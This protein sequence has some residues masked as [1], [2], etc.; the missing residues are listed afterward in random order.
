VRWSHAAT[1]IAAAADRALKLFVTLPNDS[2]L[3]LQWSIDGL[4]GHSPAGAWDLEKSNASVVIG[5]LD[6]GVDLGHP[7]LASKIWTNPGEIPANGLDDDANGYVDDVHGW[8]FGNDDA[9]ANPAPMFDELGIDVGFHGT[10]V[11]GTAAA[12]TNNLE[13]IAGAGWN[14]K[15]LPLK[16]ADADGHTLISYAVEGILYCANKHTGVLNMSVG[17][18]EAD[19]AEQALFQAVIDQAVAGN[20]VCVASAGNEDSTVP[21]FPGACNGVLCVGATT[22]SNTRAG[23]LEQR[24]VGRRRGAGLV[25]V[26]P[27]LPQLPRRRDQR[28][29][30][31]VLLRLR[32]H[33]PVHVRRRHL[34]LE[35]AHRGRVR[36]RARALPDRSAIGVINHVIQTG[37][38]LAFDKPIGRKVNAYLAVATTLA[39]PDLGP[40]SGA[41]DRA[42]GRAADAVFGRHHAGLPAWPRRRACGS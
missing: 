39:A 14:A 41:C 5:I 31:R 24:P 35:P 25:D 19:S 32:R 20:V 1:A 36:A 33:P 21:V 9:D 26:D 7:D 15:I 23:L 22:E 37:D 6:T 28:V 17:T 16:V 11:A 34:L 38:V 3:A 29:H 18:A 10:S 42:P 2:D 12:G 27:D 30:L 40:S 13:G 4:R 8:D